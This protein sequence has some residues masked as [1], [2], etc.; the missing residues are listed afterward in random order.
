[1]N[2]QKTKP[3]S[4]GYLINI[5]S[6]FR[7]LAR[8]IDMAILILRRIKILLGPQT[9]RHCQYC[10]WL[11]AFIMK[12]IQTADWSF[13]KTLAPFLF[14]YKW[15]RKSHSNIPFQTRSEQRI[16]KPRR[17]AESNNSALETSQTSQKSKGEKGKAHQQSSRCTTKWKHR[18]YRYLAHY[19]RVEEENT[20]F[21]YTFEDSLRTHMQL[22][23]KE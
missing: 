2:I 11:H 10:S 14:S 23:S 16:P 6:L 15:E 21:I 12:F 13:H 20:K 4:R 19:H 5:D 9:R 17:N 7:H 3:H 18:D 8:F 1:M 22:P